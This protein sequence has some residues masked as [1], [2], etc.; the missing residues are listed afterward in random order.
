MTQSFYAQAIRHDEPDARPLLR[1][2]S[3][4]SPQPVAD[5]AGGAMFVA[6]VAVLVF[7]FAFIGGAQ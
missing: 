3:T 7:L 1:D 4:P 2:V 5:W 6:F